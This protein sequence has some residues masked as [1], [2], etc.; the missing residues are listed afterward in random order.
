MRQHTTM[1][2]VSRDQA[3]ASLR[4]VAQQYDDALAALKVAEQRAH[5]AAFEAK[6][7]GLSQHDIATIMGSAWASAN[8]PQYPPVTDLQTHQD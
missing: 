6:N 1:S 2:N 7:A 8:N 3:E 4:S 5:Q